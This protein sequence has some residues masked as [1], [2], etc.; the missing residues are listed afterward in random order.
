M[1]SVTKRKNYILVERDGGNRKVNDCPDR[2]E[3]SQTKRLLAAS[4]FF[5]RGEEDRGNAK[6]LFSTLAKQLATNIPQ[7]VPSIRKV[8]DDDPDISE[9]GP[10]EQFE[11][12]ILQPLLEI[13]SQE[14]CMVIVIDAL[15]EC[16]GQDE[17][18]AVLRM[19][20]LVKK[21]HSLQLRFFLT[22]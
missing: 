15:D 14:V 3:P 22:K 8:I 6:R 2:G 17:V 21:S 16:E 9:K 1:G 10:R 20:P 7:L 19:L 5:K 12:L 11:K 18:K 13:Q 4:F